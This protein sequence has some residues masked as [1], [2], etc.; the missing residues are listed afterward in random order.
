MAEKRTYL[1]K[2]ASPQVRSFDQILEP[3]QKLNAAAHHGRSSAFEEAVELSKKEGFEIGYNQGLE[4]GYLDGKHQAHSEAKA[5]LA[6]EIKRFQQQLEVI[7]IQIESRVSELVS[8]YE[9]PLA[10][11]SVVVATHLIGNAIQSDE[12]A[13]ISLAKQAIAEVANASKA[14]IKVNPLD[15]SLIQSHME[16]LMAIGSSLKHIDIVRDPSIPAGCVVE[17]DG[18]IADARVDQMLQAALASIRREVTQ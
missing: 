17:T 9:R 13:T 10:E 4:Q 11:T 18:G 15:L 16:S 5:E 3:V 7:H 14:R 8:T 12:D 1:S 2:I 6:A